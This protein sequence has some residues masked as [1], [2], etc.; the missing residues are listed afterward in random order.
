MCAR[1]RESFADFYADVGPRP[2][3]R[4]SIDRYPDNDGG[5]RPGNVRWATA[6]QQA[7]NRRK[8]E[9]RAA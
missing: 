6:S 8:R 9:H 4:H 5:Y 3:P 1:W 7:R 2:S